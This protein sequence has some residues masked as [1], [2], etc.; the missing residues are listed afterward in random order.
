MKISNKEIAKIIYEIGE[1]LQIKGIPFK[2]RAYE[3]AGYSIE[4]LE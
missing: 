3:K 4:N 1:Y 2:P